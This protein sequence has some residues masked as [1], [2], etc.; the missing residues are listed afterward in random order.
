MSHRLKSSKT[1]GC[2][3][4]ISFKTSVR[5]FSCVSS[6]SAAITSSSCSDSGS[7]ECVC[8]SLEAL[9]ENYD[10]IC[11]AVKNSSTVGTVLRPAGSTY[12]ACRTTHPLGQVSVMFLVQV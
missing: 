4:A 12:N 6:S 7:S 5:T 8:R 1:I 11:C 10:K 9:L 3:S 2:L